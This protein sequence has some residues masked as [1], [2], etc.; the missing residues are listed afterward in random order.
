MSLWLPGSA[1]LTVA[2]ALAL[3]GLACVLAHRQRW[4][5]AI[6]AVAVA[7]LG[8]RGY[9]S[10][11]LALHPWDERYHAL[12]AKNLIDTPLTPRLYPAPLLSYDHR[13]WTTNYIWMH[14]PPM[15]QWLQAVSMK[16]FGVHEFA[17]RLP[18]VLV[19]TAA[20]VL[21]FY[22]GTMLVGPGVG[23]LAAMF[24]TFNGFLVDLTSGRRVS[25][26]VDTLLIFLF[27]L[28]IL[29]ALQ[30]SRRSSTATGVVLGAVCGFA[31]LTK[32][33]PALLMLPVWASMRLHTAPLRSLARELGIAGVVAAAIAMPWTIYTAFAFPIES[34]YER[35]EAL[36][37]IT[38]VL[39][40]HGGPPWR[41]VAEMPRYFG[42]LIWL[43]LV[44]AIWAVVRT[45]SS[46]ERRAL[47]LW[48]T[49]P[50]VVF[51]LCATKAPGY[52][53]VAA[54]ALFLL[55]ADVWLW[56]WQK[57]QA[58]NQFAKRLLFG[59]VLLLLAVL[60]ARHLL[61]PTGPLEQR[62]RNP[63]WVR[64]LRGLPARI[65][66]EH[67]VVFNV[68]KSIE[69]MFYTPYV[70]YPHF[71]SAAQAQSLQQRGYRVYVFSN[72]S[73]PLSELPPNVL[74]IRPE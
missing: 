3:V 74:V 66:A 54:P 15:A 8:I 42:E 22:I 36:R 35:A 26:H 25:D 4:R 49:I 70:V 43:P 71:P 39:E 30:V 28:G 18:S 72:G 50:Y 7:A 59:G 5:Y 17:L 47:L 48:V 63:K 73:A 16:T 45:G 27:E 67:A 10:A 51:S 33:F 31:Y 55:Q 58:D 19:S 12:V 34:S 23:L 14:K 21:T 56:L 62:E 41:Y 40:G 52:V 64:D 37:R 6:L 60:P 2:A 57:R 29:L 9:A 13:A 1:L 65:G 68:E 38:D 69:A 61:E 53:M 46:G 32:S 44:I 20:I 24:Q 11:D